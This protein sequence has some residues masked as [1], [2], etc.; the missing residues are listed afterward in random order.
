M[1]AKTCFCFKHDYLK[2]YKIS[3]PVWKSINVNLIMSYLKIWK[4]WNQT[5][6]WYLLTL[7][8]L[9]WFTHQKRRGEIQT[10]EN[11]VHQGLSKVF[12]FYTYSRYTLEFRSAKY[13]TLPKQ[14]IYNWIRYFCYDYV[15]GTQKGPIHI[16]RLVSGC[17]KCDFRIFIKPRGT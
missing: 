8:I 14:W 6:T 13:M 11:H 17:C 4:K 2:S 5:K 7:F 15:P 10:G 1:S 12:V 9:V 3:L 16:F